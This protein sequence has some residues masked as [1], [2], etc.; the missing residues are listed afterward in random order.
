[1]LANLLHDVRYALHGFALRPMLAVVV[2]LTLAVGIGVNVAVFSLYDRIMLR[3][4]N[5]ERPQELVKLV[6]QRA[7]GPINRISNQQG[8]SEETFSYL[9]FRDL[10]RAGAP[11]LELA[12]SRMIP[13]SLGRDGGTT[14]GSAVLV[15]GGFF[16]AL[17]VG[18]ELGR[19]LADPDIA[20]GPAS[21]V[22]L[23]YDYWQTAYS[24]DPA[25]VGETLVVG[26]HPLTIVGV[27]PRGF[28]GT[29][30]G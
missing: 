25:V 4:L 29:T 17:G 19:V 9:M 20:D 10:E 16:A 12:A 5:V 27:A 23:S 1:M 21:A 18:P 26:G 30:P 15:S 14:I 3:E 22:V 6:A 24:A 2:V 28:V 13:A 8:P 11:Y 7:D